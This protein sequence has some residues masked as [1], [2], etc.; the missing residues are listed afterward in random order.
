[1]NI[2]INPQLSSEYIERELYELEGDTI[3]LSSSTEY[4]GRIT[5]VFSEKSNGRI[6]IYNIS[7]R[8]IVDEVLDV[9]SENRI[10]LKI[11]GSTA[12][13]EFKRF[14]SRYSVL[15]MH[16]CKIQ[17]FT[18]EEL[19]DQA[20]Q[21]LDKAAHDSFN[22]VA[23]LSIQINSFEMT[24]EFISSVEEMTYQQKRIFL[25]DN[26]SS[27]FSGLRL[28]IRFPNIFIVNP[29]S[30]ISFCEAFNISAELAILRQYEFLFI[31]NNDTKNFSRNMLEVLLAQLREKVVIASPKVFD[32]EKKPIHWQ[33]RAFWGIEFNIATEAYVVKADIWKNI[34]GFRECFV[35][36]CE[37]LDLM[38]RISALGYR[39]TVVPTVS[40]DHLGGAT[41][42]KR[43]FIP[44][45]FFLRNLIWILRFNNGY[46]RV[47]F[48]T[49]FIEAKLL[50]LRRLS[51]ETSNRFQ[52]LFRIIFYSFF[53]FWAGILV[54]PKSNMTYHHNHIL[55]ISKNRVKFR[56]R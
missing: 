29:Q 17:S 20:H 23:I 7:K 5:S 31:V 14:T 27:D 48:R 8:S 21:P 28:L 37:D 22:S 49:V 6:L 12:D 15:T 55:S 50:F 54:K 35:M 24:S 2:I 56:L 47:F 33:P 39:G 3:V 19:R 1:M 18:L 11:F 38:S 34:G 16:L 26:F 25:V 44:T 43:V 32:Y 40:L 13:I 30:R 4:L 36:Y 9:L 52:D 51:G 45:Y 10:N 53:A 46:N 41:V 42:G